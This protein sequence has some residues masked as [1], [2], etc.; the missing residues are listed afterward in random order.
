MKTQLSFIEDKNTA[1][2]MLNV[3]LAEDELQ[4]AQ[5]VVNKF[6]DKAFQNRYD[7]KS[8]QEELNEQK[9]AI[10]KEKDKDKKANMQ[11]NADAL[12]DR[13]EKLQKEI[14][15]DTDEVKNDK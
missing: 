11:K 4:N 9:K 2:R 14:K 7:L 15:K 6:P 8:T 3:F 5:A 1:L 12:N 10:S 13:I